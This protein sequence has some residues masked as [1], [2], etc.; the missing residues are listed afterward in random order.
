MRGEPERTPVLF[1]WDSSSLSLSWF[2]RILSILTM[3][4]WYTCLRSTFR[5]ILVCVRVSVWGDICFN[6]L[7]TSSKWVSRQQQCRRLSTTII[8]H[9]LCLI[10][11]TITSAVFLSPQPLPPFKTWATLYVWSGMFIRGIIL[12]TW[13]VDNGMEEGK[14]DFWQIDRLVKTGW[15]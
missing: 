11:S 8:G 5:N 13:R 14:K 7:F 10:V 1:Q 12:F 15:S 6:L 2:S 4:F 9:Y 3:L